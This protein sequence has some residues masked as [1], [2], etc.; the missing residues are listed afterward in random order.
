MKYIAVVVVEAIGVREILSFLYHLD[1]LNKLLLLQR[2]HSKHMYAKYPNFPCF[3]EKIGCMHA[4]ILH[5]SSAR[6]NRAD[7]SVVTWKP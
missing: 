1:I 5:V 4:Y 6:L 7:H 3:I 2:K